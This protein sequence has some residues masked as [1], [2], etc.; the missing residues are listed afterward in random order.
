MREVWSRCELPSFFEGSNVLASCEDFF[1]VEI[2]CLCWRGAL[3]SFITLSNYV[4]RVSDL[5]TEK[6]DDNYANKLKVYSDSSRDAKIILSNILISETDILMSRLLQLGEDKGQLFVDVCANG[7]HTNDNT[8]YP[9]QCVLYDVPFLVLKLLTHWHGRT[10]RLSFVS[11]HTMRSAF[12]SVLH[13][14]YKSLSYRREQKTKSCFCPAYL[15]NFISVSC[16]PICYSHASVTFLMARGKLCWMYIHVA[17]LG[18]MCCKR[19]LSFFPFFLFSLQ[20]TLQPPAYVI[21][22][23]VLPVTNLLDVLK[24]VDMYI[25]Y[26]LN[27]KKVGRRYI[28]VFLKHI[29]ALNL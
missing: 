9:L 11:W 29:F 15:Y 8:L 5:R 1:E 25:K 24:I 26:K 10:H 19:Q 18:F 14:E 28:T 3:R 22:A 17:R 2:L 12:K 6:Y 13:I 4:F 7:L 20:K 21:V 23:D 16:K 27:F